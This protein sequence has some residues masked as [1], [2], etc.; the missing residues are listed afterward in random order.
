[1]TVAGHKELPVMPCPVKS[2]SHE[3][4]KAIDGLSEPVILV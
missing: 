3:N 2:P 4:P 1:M